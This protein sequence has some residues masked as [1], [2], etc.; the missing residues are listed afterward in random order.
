MLTAMN[1]EEGDIA[2]FFVE[3]LGLALAPKMCLDQSHT[4]EEVKKRYAFT[5]GKKKWT[6]RF[7]VLQG[8]FVQSFAPK[9]E[10]LT[11]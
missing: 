4:F 5:V 7:Q 2:S 1:R 10:E 9:F 6:S 8:I 3:D 11:A